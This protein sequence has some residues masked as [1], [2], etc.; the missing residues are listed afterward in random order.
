[1][2]GGLTTGSRSAPDPHPEL[3]HFGFPLTIHPP[4]G[5][6]AHQNHPLP[7]HQLG[8]LVARPASQPSAQRWLSDCANHYLPSDLPEAGTE[9]FAQNIS[10]NPTTCVSG[11]YQSYPY[12]K[13]LLYVDV[14]HNIRTKKNCKLEPTTKKLSSVGKILAQPYKGSLWTSTGQAPSHQPVKPISVS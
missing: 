9:S 10:M 6:P 13:Q 1:M 7:V 3:P 5:K 2:S 14:S 4:A 11:K 8:H 12:H